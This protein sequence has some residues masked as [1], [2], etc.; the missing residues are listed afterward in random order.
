MSEGSLRKHERKCSSADHEVPRD[1]AKSGTNIRNRSVVTCQC[2][3][4]NFP[5]NSVSEACKE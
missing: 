4:S 2:C 3:M 5:R 1:P